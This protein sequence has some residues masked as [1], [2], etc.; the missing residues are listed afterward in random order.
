MVW[1]ALKREITTGTYYDH[2]HRRPVDM[3]DRA[4]MLTTVESFKFNLR[5]DDTTT[6]KHKLL[7]DDDMK[8]L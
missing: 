3:R 4:K 7:W 2:I 8:W 1:A 5:N 6:N